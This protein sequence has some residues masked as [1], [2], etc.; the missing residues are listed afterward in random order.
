[1]SGGYPLSG[2][3]A[4]FA[5]LLGCYSCALAVGMNSKAFAADDETP[6]LDM[7]PQDAVVVTSGGDGTADVPITYSLRI[8]KEPDRIKLKGSVS[9]EEDYKTL[10]GM[11]KATFPA[12]DLS[13]R[14]KVDDKAPDSDGEIRGLSFALKVL[15]YVETGQASVDNNGLSL[16]GAATTAVILTEVERL[17]KEDK[18][19]GV[20]IKTLRVA[21]PKKSWNASIKSEGVL[22]IKGV[23]ASEQNKEELYQLALTKFSYLSIQDE[24]VVDKRL[25]DSWAKAARRSI[26]M[27]QVLDQGSV[28]VTEQMV[29]LRGNAPTQK[30]LEFIDSIGT[31]LPSG[32]AL[33]SEVSAPILPYE[34]VAVIPSDTEAV[35]Q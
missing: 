31:R 3:R 18:P 16:D 10:I 28:E 19:T 33:K 24:T 6:Q 17:V 1:M 23:V 30:A 20:P 35:A 14:I 21:P 32:V 26:E 11:V 4:L 5:L 22:R 7:I 34:G 12:I 2:L 15:G 27:L 9:S 25:G 29:H 8:Y 13:D